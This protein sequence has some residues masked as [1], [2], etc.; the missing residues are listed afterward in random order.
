[1]ERYVIRGGRHGYARLQVLARARRADTVELLRRAGLRPGMR[2]LDLGCGGGDV[3]FELASLAGAQG[4]VTGIDMDEVK[5][6]LAREAATGR[7]FANVEFR[8][9]NVNDW[10]EPGAYDF[11]YCRSCSST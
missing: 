9:G 4:S 10:A 1:V 5:L 2:C 7:G 3:S 11:V 6:A 8:T